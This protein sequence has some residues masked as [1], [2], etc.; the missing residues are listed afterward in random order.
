MER[1]VLTLKIDLT[2]HIFFRF[3]FPLIYSF[4]L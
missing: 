4:S 3:H 2:V 1:T